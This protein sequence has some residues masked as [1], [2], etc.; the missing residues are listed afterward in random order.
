MTAEVIGPKTAFNITFMVSGIAGLVGAGAPTF[1]S[2]AT[3]CAFFGLG[4]GG[5]QP[6]DSAIFL[7]RKVWQKVNATIMKI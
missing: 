4:T 7:V 5:N 2:I 1:A 3:L 6:V